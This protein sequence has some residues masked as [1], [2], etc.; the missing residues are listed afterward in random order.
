[1]CRLW[2]DTPL[3]LLGMQKH[4][5]QG[6][7]LSLPLQILPQSLQKDCDFQWTKTLHTDKLGLANGLT[8]SNEIIMQQIGKQAVQEKNEGNLRIFFSD[9]RYFLLWLTLFL[10]AKLQNFIFIPI[11][12]HPFFP[13][14]Q[15]D[16]FS[17]RFL[18]FIIFPLQV[19]IS[20][21]IFQSFPEKIRYPWLLPM[22]ESGLYQKP[23]L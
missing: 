11:S 8:L 15:T 10:Q 19:S 21:V 16:T 12:F 7:W 13:P 23:S 20:H 1:M 4:A 14:L 17:N 18:Y 22:A 9:K 6:N 3:K 2:S 5:E